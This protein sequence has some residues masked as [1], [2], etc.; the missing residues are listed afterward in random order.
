MPRSWPG[1]VVWAVCAAALTGLDGRLDLANLAMILVLASALAALWLPPVV[2]MLACA[3]AVLAFNVAFVP[4]RGR[5]DVDLQQHTLLL[6]TMLAVGWIISLLMALQR[7]LAAAERRH[8]VRAEQLQQLGES[9]RDA[10]DPRTC[11]PQLCQV[12][13][14]LNGDAVMLILVGDTVPRPLTATPPIDPALCQWVGEPDAD[15]RTGLWLCLQQTQPMGPGTGRHEGQPGW[16]L[17]MRGRRS[18]FG[19]A[20]LR[21]PA[22]PVDADL[23]R[24]HAQ[25]LCDQM[26]LAIERALAART[27]AE[28]CAE[29]QDQKLRNTLLAAI[30]HDYRTPLATILGAAGAL[31]DQGD[32]LSLAQRQ[33]LATTIADEADQLARLTTNTLQ[34]V[35]LETP[36]LALTL[37]WESAEELVGAV[38]RRVRQRR[39]VEPDE[40]GP[41]LRARLEPELPLLRCDAL[42]LTQ[43]LENL[44]D[45]ALKYAGTSGVEILVRREGGDRLVLAVR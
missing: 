40:G 39:A 10:D 25:S 4:P 11:G 3:A 41:R 26:G 8:T 28:A 21:L 1:A 18:S 35:R 20:L 13:S 6:L 44:V 16:Y 5:L 33:R 23:T 38:L 30:S 34:M 45:N 32:R 15:E 19:A 37:D 9:L 42:L 29:A 7:Q 31:H 2:A 17:P 24:A 14:R 43:M 27:A 22:V 12:L 36:G